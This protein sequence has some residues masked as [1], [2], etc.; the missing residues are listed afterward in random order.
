MITRNDFLH[1]HLHPIYFKH[2]HI[3]QLPDFVRVQQFHAA[4]AFVKV[5]AERDAAVPRLDFARAG[6]ELDV[7]WIGRLEH[8]FEGGD[9]DAVH[10]SNM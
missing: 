2:A 4:G 6:P 3:S 7:Y 5:I 9:V 8:T 1:K 10:S